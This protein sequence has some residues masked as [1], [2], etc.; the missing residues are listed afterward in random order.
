MKAIP[1]W[2]AAAA[3]ACPVLLVGG[4][5]L[6]AALQPPSYD[7][8]RDTISELAGR[9][10]TDPWVMTAALACLGS[11]FALAALGLRPA[12]AAGR[13]LLAGQGLATLVIA[14]FP[15]PRHGYSVVHELAVVAAAATC[16]TWPVFA[17]RRQHPAPL[18]KQAPSFAAAA[19][20]FGLV[21]WYALESH[22]TLLGLAERCA[23][24]APPLWLLAVV[25]TTWHASGRRAAGAR[26]EPAVSPEP[27]GHA[28]GW[29]HGH[30]DPGAVDR[31]P[32]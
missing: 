32:C 7:P 5:L 26:R 17:S 2:A 14:A 12:G 22:G 30:G 15:Q 23:A 20:L 19:L 9:G 6:G 16:C 31:R 21:A 4:Y 29:D 3:A 27:A 18:L 24:T 8:V 1:W 28:P 10:A 25:V 13:I 11:C